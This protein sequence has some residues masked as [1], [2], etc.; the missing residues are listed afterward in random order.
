[1][2][3]NDI[4][5]ILLGER[6]RLSAYAWSIVRDT[7]VVEDVIQDVI[8]KALA[9]KAKIKD[10]GHL[11]AWARTATRNQSIDFLRKHR[12]RVVTLEVDTLELLHENLRSRESS[13]TSARKDALHLCVSKL[14]EKSR[15]VLKLRY[16]EEMRG[17]AVAERL[18][19]TVDAVYQTLSRLHRQL[20][21]CIESRLAVEAARR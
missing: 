17:A 12:G 8:V 5:T 14:P 19:R 15:K 11:Q 3:E 2:T 13:G 20:R 7:H 18:N 16:Q 6:V 10:E 21:K 4:V 9:N 1:M